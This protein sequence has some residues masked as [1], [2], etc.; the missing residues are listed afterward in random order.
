MEKIIKE[1]KII[2]NNF[3]SFNGVKKSESGNLIVSGL[4]TKFNDEEANFNGYVYK[5]GCYNEFC[6]NYFQK[7]NKNIPVELLHNSFDINHLC[8]KVIEFTADDN[9]ATIICE[10]SRHATLF[11]NIEGL[12][13]D[14]ILQGFSDTSYV[15]DGYID[16]EKGL[17]FVNKCEILSVS[18]VQNPAVAGSNL[19]INNSTKFNFFK[20]K[21]DDKKGEKHNS[22]FFNI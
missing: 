14:G 5:S 1:N 4:L 22:F 21:K 18:L 7:N 13:E 8:G 10:I 19:T 12:I 3:F 16:N 11:N 17:L 20:T 6:E 9:Q 15:T 2:V